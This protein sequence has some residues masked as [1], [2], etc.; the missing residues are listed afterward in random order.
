[1]N[2]TTRKLHRRLLTAA[3][4][5][6]ATRYAALN[7]AIAALLAAGNLVQASAHLIRL[8]LTDDEIRSFR[9]HYG[10]CV[11]RAYRAAT[12]GRAPLVCWVDVDGYYRRVAVYF[13]FDRAFA[14]G[15]KAYKRL[16]ALIGTRALEVA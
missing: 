14:A 12:G 3:Q 11:K 9:S 16:A 1:M 15:V 5:N 13:P 10:K 7:G 2:S 8:G 6:R 4:V